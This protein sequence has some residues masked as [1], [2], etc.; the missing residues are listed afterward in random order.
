MTEATERLRTPTGPEWP[1][2]GRG[3]KLSA[4]RRILFS[5]APP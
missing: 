5:A 3:D 1:G 4:V 2:S